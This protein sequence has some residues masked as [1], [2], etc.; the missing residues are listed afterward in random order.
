MWRGSPGPLMLGHARNSW[1]LT[2][3]FRNSIIVEKPDKFLYSDELYYARGLLLGYM[4]ILLM[5]NYHRF[6][7]MVFQQVV[8]TRSKKQS[9][10]MR[11]VL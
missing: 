5:S 2:E 8:E 1:V 4:C 7:A 9:K 3:R 10:Q 11:H 6:S